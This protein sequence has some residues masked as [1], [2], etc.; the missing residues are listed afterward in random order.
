MVHKLSGAVWAKTGSVQPAGLLRYWRAGL[1]MT[2]TLHGERLRRNWTFVHEHS[3]SAILP[4]SA[5]KKES[6]IWLSFDFPSG[7]GSKTRRER[8]AD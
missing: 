1:A 2:Y 6:Q 7:L 3:P 5:Q 8:V 4:F